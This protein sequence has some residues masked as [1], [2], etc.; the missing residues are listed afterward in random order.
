MERPVKPFFS[1]LNPFKRNFQKKT[2]KELQTSLTSAKFKS[3]WRKGEK[4]AEMKV[5]YKVESG[6]K[7]EEL[8]IDAE[9]KAL[10]YG[11]N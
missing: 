2:F 9:H 4:T 1:F 10:K 5:A 3:G 6:V 8:N 11:H 7:K